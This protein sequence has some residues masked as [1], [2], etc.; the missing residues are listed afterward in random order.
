MEFLIAASAGD[1]QWNFLGYTS[2]SQEGA[3]RAQ[4]KQQLLHLEDQYLEDLGGKLCQ[5]LIGKI[6]YCVDMRQDAQTGLSGL[7]YSSI[8][9][10]LLR[11]DI[12]RIVISM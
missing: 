8:S 9:E 6:V 3:V 7:Y 2:F 1:F 4:F 10:S 5:S 12:E 11:S